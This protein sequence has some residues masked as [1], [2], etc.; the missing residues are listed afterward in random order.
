MIASE[1]RTLMTVLS[2]LPGL[3][4][5]SARRATLHMM[6]QPRRM[7]ELQAALADVAESVRPCTVCGALDTCSPCTVCQNPERDDSCLCV[8]ADVG[9]LWAMERAMGYRGRYHVLGG[10]L[11]A[12][13]GVGPAELDCAR[14]WR[15]IESSLP[16]LKEVILALNATM[17]GQTTTHYLHGQLKKFPVRI[18]ALAQGIPVGAELEWLDDGTLVTALFS[19]RE[20]LADPE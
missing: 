11:S 2:R 16:T 5:R 14:L 20:V 13:E 1:I 18:S 3:G 17:E 9:D 8:V 7:K 15:R 19:R 10:L 12:L 6:S 4:P